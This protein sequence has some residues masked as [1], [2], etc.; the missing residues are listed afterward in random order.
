M[1]LI[2]CKCILGNDHDSFQAIYYMVFE[3][4]EHDLAGLLLNKKVVFTLGEIKDIL[5]QILN[6]LQYIHVNK[7]N[8]KYYTYYNV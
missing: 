1:K 8:T 3:F 2:Q 5:K 7:V 6:G 4:C